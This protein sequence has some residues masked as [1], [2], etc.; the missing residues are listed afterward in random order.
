MHIRLYINKDGQ[1]L[2]VTSVNEQHD[3]PV[4]KVSKTKSYIFVIH[5]AV[6]K[7]YNNSH[8]ILVLDLLLIPCSVSTV[9]M[10]GQSIKH[11]LVE[12]S[13]QLS[14]VCCQIRLSF[15]LHFRVHL[16]LSMDHLR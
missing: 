13:I 7:M 11:V 5:R 4:D 10:F 16:R 12:A 8:V 3:H 1:T 9:Y 6:F 14:N 2:D 15:C